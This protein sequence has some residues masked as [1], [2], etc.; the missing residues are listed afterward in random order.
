MI[1]Y[2]CADGLIS[3]KTYDEFLE[4]FND[5][6]GKG[7]NGKYYTKKQLEKLKQQKNNGYEL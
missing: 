4:L 7:I 1:Y 6:K 3:Q 2:L 5:N